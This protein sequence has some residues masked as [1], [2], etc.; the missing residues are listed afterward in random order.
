MN[1]KQILIATTVSHFGYGAATG[2]LYSPLSKKV[3][4]PAVVKGV[5]FG[6]FI[7]AASYLGLLPMIGMSA[8]GHRE[9]VR[10]N[11]MMIAAHAVWGATMAVVAELLIDH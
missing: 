8:S 11:L 2:V 9:P 10:R 6:L 4:L 3:P 1:K 5:L 7:W